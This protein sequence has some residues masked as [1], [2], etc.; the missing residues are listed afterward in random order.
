[1]HQ[2]SVKNI[3]L[4]VDCLSKGGAE[5]IASRLSVALSKRGFKLSIISLRDDI[6][7]QHAGRLFN[8]GKNEPKFQLIKQLK[9]GVLFYK[10]Y[11]KVNADIYIDFRMRNRFFMETFLHLFV[12]EKDKM[13]MRINN[14]NIFFPKRNNHII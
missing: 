7:Y 9:K 4:I 6:T 1:M 10:Y 8:L 14:F 3:C 12:F 2:N 11:K 13:I 5:K